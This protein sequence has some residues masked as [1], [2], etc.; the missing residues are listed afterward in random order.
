MPIIASCH[1]GNT[2]RCERPSYYGS[3]TRD[4][5][6]NPGDCKSFSNFGPANHEGP[7]NH[8]KT[9]PLEYIHLVSPIV[10]FGG[11]SPVP[12]RSFSFTCSAPVEFLKLKFAAATASPDCQLLKRIVY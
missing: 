5:A 11:K 1:P 12:L 8:P 10:K 7:D 3:R 9:H 6:V 4:H 2:H